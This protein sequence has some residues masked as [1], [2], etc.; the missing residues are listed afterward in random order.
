MCASFSLFVWQVDN[1]LKPKMVVDEFLQQSRPK[2]FPRSS[3]A[4]L[5]FNNVRT[6]CDINKDTIHIHV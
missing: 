3:P 6:H 5:Q 2:R 1:T 4:R